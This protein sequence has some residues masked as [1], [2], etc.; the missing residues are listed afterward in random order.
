MK[1]QTALK[2][3]II[4]IDEH[5]P[6]G[7]EDKEEPKK[8][9]QKE[10]KVPVNSRKG[11]KPEYEE[12]RQ[13]TTKYEQ[14]TVEET[15]EEFIEGFGAPLHMKNDRK[16]NQKGIIVPIE[17]KESTDRRSDSEPR[18]FTDSK[19]RREAQLKRNDTF[20]IAS[21]IKS[22]GC[23]AQDTK[24]PNRGS[25]HEE[26]SLHKKIIVNIKPDMPKSENLTPKS[27]KIS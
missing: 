24:H 12:K 16:S 25:G 8:H 4:I 21:K 6:T 7:K 5:L 2:V 26:K 18:N 15:K 27:Q 10:I 19:E 13:F 17:I 14:I 20:T 9:N 11:F 1:N 22:K 3:P 23:E